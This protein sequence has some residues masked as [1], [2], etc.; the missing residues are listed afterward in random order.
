MTESAV[1]AEVGNL[2]NEPDATQAQDGLIDAVKDA[3]SALRKLID[4]ENADR[5]ELYEILAKNDNITA[6]K[7]A[8]RAAKRNFEKAKAGE[9]LKGEDGKWTKKAS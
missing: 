2:T 1:G 6:D 4:D 3:D 5:K 7:V 8:E 9:Y